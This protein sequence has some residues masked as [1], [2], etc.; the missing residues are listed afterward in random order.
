MVNFH[1]PNIILLDSCAYHAPS[2]SLLNLTKSILSAVAFV[3]LSHTVDGLYMWVYRLTLLLWASRLDLR[4]FISDG[5]SLLLSALSGVSSEDIYPTGGRHGSVVGGPSR[6][7]LCL[8]L[9][10][11]LGLIFFMGRFIPLRASPRS[12]P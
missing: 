3:K 7:H 10:V 6:G 4:R 1:D 11:S 5:S 12:W 9:L 8:L 2:S